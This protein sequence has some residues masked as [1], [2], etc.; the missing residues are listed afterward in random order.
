[1]AYFMQP[2]AKAFDV[3][4]TVNR[5]HRDAAKTFTVEHCKAVHLLMV[6]LVL[7]LGKRLFNVGP[8]H[9]V[10]ATGR[11]RWNRSILVLSGTP[12]EHKHCND[13]EAA[14]HSTGA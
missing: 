5:R 9:D 10:K 6:K 1:M 14:D 8:F 7:C 2:S 12:R 13:G 11:A 4:V 3:A